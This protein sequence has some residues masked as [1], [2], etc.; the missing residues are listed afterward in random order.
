M[1]CALS[2]GSGCAPERPPWTPNEILQ[3]VEPELR[4]FDGVTQPIA[5]AHILMWQ[6]ERDNE[7]AF[8]VEEALLWTRSDTTRAGESWA[9]LHA[10]RHPSSD[11]RWHRSVSY[12]ETKDESRIPHTR[13]GFRRFQT[14]PTATEVC[15]FLLHVRGLGLD[16]GFRHISG[17]FPSFAWRRLLGRDAPC[18]FSGEV[19]T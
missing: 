6:I 12:I 1:L 16:S 8:I 14:Q 5:V 3:D 15:A 13:L 19:K 4:E 18:S 11:N 17:G 9:L 7:R 10:F 2:L